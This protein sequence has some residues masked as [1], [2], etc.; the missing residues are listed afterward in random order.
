MSRLVQ[1]NGEKTCS[2]CKITKSIVDFYKRGGKWSPETRHSVCKECTKIRVRERHRNDPERRRNNDL[3]RN[4]GITIEDYSRMF[5]NQGGVCAICKRPGDGRWSQLCVDHDHV[6]G[7]VRELLCIR[8]NMILG[9]VNDNPLLLYGL[10]TYLKK[11][12]C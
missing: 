10:A 11:H 5:E 4:Y 6:T 3:K 8:C 1:T 2:N 7:K 12:G 9:R